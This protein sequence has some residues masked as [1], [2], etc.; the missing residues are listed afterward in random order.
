VFAILILSR[1]P[2]KARSVSELYGS[3]GGESSAT[4][5]YKFLFQT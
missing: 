4:P 1:V 2:F 3:G 5:K